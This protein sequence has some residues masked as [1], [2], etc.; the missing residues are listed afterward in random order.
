MKTN[1]QTKRTR[2]HIMAPIIGIEQNDIHRSSL[3]LFDIGLRSC[4]LFCL[5]HFSPTLLRFVLSPRRLVRTPQSL[6]RIHDPSARGVCMKRGGVVNCV[7]RRREND[8]EDDQPQCQFGGEGRRRHYF[9][10]EAPLRR[11]VKN[12]ESGRQGSD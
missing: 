8:R 12:H 7:E 6:G 1:C 10:G 2:A 4:R 9:T 5:Q 3:L 11:R